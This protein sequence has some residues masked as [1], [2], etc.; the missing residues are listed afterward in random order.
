MSVYFHFT[1]AAPGGRALSLFCLHQKLPGGMQA[2]P[3]G[4]AEGGAAA[5]GQ[6][7]P[8]VIPQAGGAQ[9]VAVAVLLIG[10]DP[11]KISVLRQKEWLRDGLLAA[12]AAVL[13]AH[14]GVP[15][16]LPEGAETPALRLGADARPDLGIAGDEA[17]EVPALRHIL[18]LRLPA[19]TGPLPAFAGE[20]DPA[21]RIAQGRPLPSMRKRERSPAG[22]RSLSL[23]FGIFR[24]NPA[25]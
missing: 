23:F 10:E 6:G 25:Q 12:A 4:A 19:E 5:E 20:E 13:P 18:R 2:V 8:P 17:E 9:E 14:G 15:A 24:G 11:G 1:D 21:F 7:L 22:E 16:L 3:V